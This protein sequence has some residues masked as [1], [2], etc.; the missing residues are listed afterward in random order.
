[1]SKRIRAYTWVIYT[2]IYSGEKKCN[3]MEM[4]VGYYVNFDTLP[5]FNIAKF[6]LMKTVFNLIKNSNTCKLFKIRAQQII[7]WYIR[8]NSFYVLLY[9]KKFIKLY[10]EKSLK[11]LP[12]TLI[13][14]ELTK[15]WA[16]HFNILII[17]Q[18]WL[19]YY[20]MI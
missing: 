13:N 8:I 20:K 7:L 16:S 3:Y 14:W 1:M 4:H 2:E 9:N 18:K 19:K 11:P 17:I 5:S 10:K 6:S 12:L 15:L